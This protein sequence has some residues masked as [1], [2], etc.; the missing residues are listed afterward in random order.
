[1]DGVGGICKN[2]YKILVENVKGETPP[3]RLRHR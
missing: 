2:V 1:M 3:G